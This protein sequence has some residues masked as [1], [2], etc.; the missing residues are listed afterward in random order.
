MAAQ[1]D[2]GSF[3]DL[4]QA[5]V[6]GLADR[7]VIPLWPALRSA[8]PYDKPIRNA[9]PYAWRYADLRGDLLRAGELTPIEKAERRVLVLSNPGIGLAQMMATPTIYIGLQL[10]LP[11][12]T[13]PNHRHSPSAIRFV[14]EG[15]GAYTMVNGEKCPMEKG[16]LI[17]TPS[18]TWHEHGHDGKNPVV[19]MD[20]LDL[21]VLL[22]LEA[23]Y[24]VEGEPQKPSN[25]PDRSQTTYRRAGL[26]PY[27]SL[28][29]RNTR[30]PLI[31][32]PWKEVRAALHDLAATAD[33]KE[34]VH[35]AYV[36]PETG[37]ECL[38]IL[39]FSAQ[40]LRAGEEVSVPLRSCSSVI[41]VI[42][43][44][45][46]SEIDGKTFAWSPSDTI[47]VPTY[48]TVK[49][50]AKGGKPAFLFHVDDA[51][52]QR[53]IGIYEDATGGLLTTRA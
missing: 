30:Y 3:A 52:L 49:H 48:S 43:G 7:A 13:A 10:I 45:G 23:S 38:P 47:A 53:K 21:P 2:L 51:P 12:E 6:K 50:R 36:N 34:A 44:E 27:A 31:R 28:A 22:K 25:R 20:A 19:W 32:F 17:L 9:V 8:L 18:G 24:A 1:Q 39:G 29:Q 16:D 40:M 26:L 42:E 14:I 41:H 35:L 46:E 5:Y 11:G 33:A 37:A 4:P 15:D